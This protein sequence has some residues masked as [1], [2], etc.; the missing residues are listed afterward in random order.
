MC[1]IC[2]SSATV[3]IRKRAQAS[4][5]AYS[6]ILGVELACDKES[7]KQILA[8]AGIPVP[9]GN[10][11][12]SLREL[13]ESLDWLGGYPI[14]VKPLD[15]NH[16][17]GITLD[18]RSWREAEAAYDKAREVADGV[19]VEH[20]YTGRDH[21]VLVVDH[22]VIAVAERRPAHVIGNG[23]RHHYRAN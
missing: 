23:S 2:C 1:A 10:V 6:N 22:K 21:R 8:G 17:R 13:E 3:C 4:L 9:K 5:T 19:I 12:Y 11:V 18:I 14:V 7:T 15:G 20:Y 16:G